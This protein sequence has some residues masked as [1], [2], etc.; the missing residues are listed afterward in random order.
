MQRTDSLLEL[1]P[2][3]DT[4]L[5]K[6][7]FDSRADLH[8]SLVSLFRSMWYIC[9]LSG[10]LSTPSRIADWQ[11]AALVRIAS[12]TPGLLRGTGNDFVE[13]ELEFSTILK[14]P[15]QVLVS[16]PRAIKHHRRSR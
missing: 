12:H 1:I 4:F 7:N 6:A 2:I 10:F 15:S 9:L 14:S 3:V 8:P 11:R 16:F 5:S 13:T